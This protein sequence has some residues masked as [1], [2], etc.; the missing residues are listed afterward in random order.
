MVRLYPH[1]HILPVQGKGFSLMELA[2]VLVVV[3]LLLGG[4]LRPL[5]AQRDAKALGDTQKQLADIRDALLGFAIANDRLPCPAS[6]GSYGRESFCSSAQGT[7]IPTTPDATPSVMTHGRCSN[8]FDGFVPGASLG[9]SPVDAQGYL[10]DGWANGSGNRIRY[11]IST[12]SGS[13]V[14]TQS[15]GMKVKTIAALQPD[16]KVCNAGSAVLHAGNATAS[17][18]ANTFLT[19]DAIAVIYS[20]GKNAAVGGTSNDEKHNPNTTSGNDPDYVVPDP[21]FV[22]AMASPDFDDVMI[23]LSGNTLYNRMVT[24]GKLP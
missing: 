23:W 5:A 24:A 15:L 19:A 13:Y 14:F 20:L 4:L 8:P 18:A 22:T 2:V 9:L 10:L 16:L 17:C 1:N 3:T 21:V 12:A 6:N 7:C 11:A